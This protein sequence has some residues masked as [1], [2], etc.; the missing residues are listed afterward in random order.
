M[1]D[2]WGGYVNYPPP[3]EVRPPEIFN[4]CNLYKKLLTSVT[5]WGP[6]KGDCKS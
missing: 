1:L 2:D 6:S 4:A 3:G 5:I